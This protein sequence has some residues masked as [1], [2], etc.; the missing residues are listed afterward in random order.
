MTNLS[1]IVPG[2]VTNVVDDTTPQLGGNLDANGNDILIDD[3]NSIKDE[4]G[5]EQIKFSTT[6]IAVNE[7]TI[8]NAATG[9]FPIIRATGEA[10][11]GLQF[12]N[13][14]AEEILILDAIA[15]AVNE[16]TIKNAATGNNPIIAATGEA[17]TGINFENS[18]SEEILILDG[19]ATAVN[20][21]TIANAVA[22]SGP[23]IQATGGDSNIDIEMIPKGTGAVNLADAVLLRSQL[24]DYS[25]TPYATSSTASTILDVE[26]GNVFTFTLTEATTITTNSTLADV[27]GSLTICATAAAGSEYAITWPGTWKWAGGSAPATFATGTEHI[28]NLMWTDGDNTAKFYA[29]YI[30]SYATA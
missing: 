25:E 28:V 7:V 29:T 13:S 6:A 11:T 20:E 10:D 19:V 17:D 26:N 14:E 24:K 23:E 9:D 8:K 27:A 2:Q 1:T 4:S 5:N 21:I 16:V 12:E 22:S 15:S 30:N 3:G 18:E